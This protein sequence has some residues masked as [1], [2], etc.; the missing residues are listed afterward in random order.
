M[1]QQVLV[2]GQPCVG[3]A[4][5]RILTGGTYEDGELVTVYKEQFPEQQAAFH[6]IYIAT[7][8]NLE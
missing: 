8:I 6:A 1:G 3:D 7:G 4:S 5:Y 2:E